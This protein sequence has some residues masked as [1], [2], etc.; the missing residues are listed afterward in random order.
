MPKNH[1]QFDCII[2]GR[3]VEIPLGKMTIYSYLCGL[4][5]P[6][7]FFLHMKKIFL[8]FFPV[9]FTLFSN[10]QSPCGTTLSP[11]TRAWLNNYASHR[12]QYPYSASSRELQYVPIKFHLVGKDDGVGYYPLVYLWQ[13]LCELNEKYA[14]VGFYFYIYGDLHYINN[15]DYFYHDWNDG[16]DMMYNNNVEDVVNVYFVGDPAGNC[17]YFHVWT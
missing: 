12:E 5:N 4:L 11:E 3:N 8:V 14:P 15:T 2:T 13:T 17:G 9:L 1:R 7:L 16:A 10:A 6:S